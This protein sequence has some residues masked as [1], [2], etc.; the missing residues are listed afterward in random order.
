MAEL[1]PEAG[2]EVVRCQ[3]PEA[4]GQESWPPEGAG[5]DEARTWAGWEGCRYEG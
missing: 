5:H 1:E 3:G 4:V 2:L